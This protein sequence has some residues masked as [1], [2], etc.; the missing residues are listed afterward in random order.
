MKKIILFASGNG[1]N[2]ENII[3]YFKA[4]EVTVVG[5]FTN[6]S[7]A[8]VLEKVSRYGIQT[9][10]FS[11]EEFTSG[12]VL[13][14]IISFEP[15]LIVLAGFLWKIPESIISY[16]TNRIINI[17]PSLLPKYGGKGMYGMNVHQ[18]VLDNRDIETG[19]TIHYVNNDYD[20]GEFIFQQSVMIDD[21]F[22][23]AD[24]AVKIHEL[25]YRFLPVVIKRILIG[26]EKLG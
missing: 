6:N 19:I 3:E 10:I 23:A 26:Y 24:I 9:V 13:D 17:H 22:S 5:V 15:D 21:C 11:R 2:V 1:S 16:Y 4:S 18:S 20:D 12:F 14:K 25:E 8:K 7:N